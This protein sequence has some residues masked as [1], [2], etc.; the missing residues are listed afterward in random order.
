M[1]PKRI[2]PM[3]CGCTDCIIGAYSVPLSQATLGDIKRLL[4]GEVID[5]TGL[6]WDEAR[7][8]MKTARDAALSDF[9]DEHR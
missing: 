9:I 1:R 8:R 4:A 6:Y 2:D 3:R 5:A 7:D